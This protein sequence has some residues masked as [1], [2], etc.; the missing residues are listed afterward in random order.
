MKHRRTDDQ[1]ALAFGTEAEINNRYFQ[2]GISRSKVQGDRSQGLSPWT[3]DIKQTFLASQFL[4]GADFLGYLQHAEVF[5]LVV[6]D[7]KITN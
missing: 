3:L 4:D 6:V 2:N 5:T 7:W 1:A